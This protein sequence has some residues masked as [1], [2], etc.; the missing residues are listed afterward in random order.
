MKKPASGDNSTTRSILKKRST[1]LLKLKRSLSLLRF[2]EK[3]SR[4]ILTFREGNTEPIS[5]SF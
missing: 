2:S 3:L 4:T 1:V 5:E